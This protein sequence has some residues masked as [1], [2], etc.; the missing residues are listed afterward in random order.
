[1][2][3]ED[4]FQ[5]FRE[6]TIGY[7]QV[8]KTP[9]GNVRMVYADWT[10]S[11]R[12]YGPIEK[13]MI[14]D[15]GPFVGNTHSESSETGMLM[16]KAYHFARQRIKKHVNADEND[17]IITAGSGTTGVINKLQRL[18]GI[19][20]SEKLRSYTCIPQDLK[21]VVF[22]THME[23][24]SNQT[25]WLETLADVKVITPGKDGLIDLNKLEE[26]LNTYA[27]RKF[28]IG[29]FTACSN[30][31]GI[32]TPYHK[33]A[34]LMHQNGG[35]CFVD[36]AASAPYTRINMHP[37]DPEEK[38]DAVFFSPHKFLGGPATSGVLIFDSRLYSN[39]VPDNPG[40]GTVDW[41]NP[42]GGHKYSSDIETR[43]DGGTPGFLQAVK[44]ALCL[45]LKDKMNPDHMLKRE[46]ELMKIL[47][48]GV[49]SV[50]GL[51]ILAGNVRERLG[52]LSFYAEDIHYNLLVKI[53]SDRFG[54][55]SRGGCSCAGTYGHFLLN[56]DQ[57]TS[58]K[59]TRMIDSGNL[60][61]K[62]G[63]VR[64]SIH[65]MM[66]D[67]QA[68]YI[69]DAVKQTVRNSKKWQD[70]Y[71]YDSALNEFKNIRAPEQENPGKEWFSL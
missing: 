40:G 36:F 39:Q 30:V 20:I 31:T 60:S 70:D 49:G 37:A 28:K 52:I 61:R 67:D 1:M 22:L 21:P 7:H 68:H 4:Y 43:E 65:P 3:L 13:K 2:Q 62:P 6:N 63:W 48:A 15:F 38:L 35:V 16:T 59:I 53:L 17:V 42:W 66:T 64:L 18:L 14:N 11:G 41:T 51:H 45:E 24:H 47:F 32:Q 34:K 33:M 5:E 55:Q 23:H 58:R 27:N 19:K 46:N 71:R 9:Y 44:T 25:S 54:I 10:A 26:L 56:I 8:Y 12:L 50:E 57:R 69:A 29:S